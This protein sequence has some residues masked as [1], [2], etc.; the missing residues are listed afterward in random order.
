MSDKSIHDNFHQI[1][2]ACENMNT[3]KSIQKDLYILLPIYLYGTYTYTC[4]S[5][6]LF[7]FKNVFCYNNTNSL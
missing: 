2:E 6:I 1:L 5:N 3:C 7:L 4:G